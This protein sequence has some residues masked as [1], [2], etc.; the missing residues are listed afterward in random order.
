MPGAAQGV[1]SVVRDLNRAWQRLPDSVFTGQ[2][3]RAPGSLP[4]N[5]GTKP[6]PHPLLRN[7]GPDVLVLSAGK[8]AA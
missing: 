2:S 6:Q 8:A 4:S 5:T 7:Q 1:S 3:W